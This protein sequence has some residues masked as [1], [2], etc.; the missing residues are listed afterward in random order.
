MDRWKPLTSE[1]GQ[2]NLSDLDKSE[3]S[4]LIEEQVQ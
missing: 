2:I 4:K 3:V 1:R